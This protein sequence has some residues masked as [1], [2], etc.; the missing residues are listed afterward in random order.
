MREEREGKK[1]QAYPALPIVRA[2]TIF[3]WS[4]DLVG[5][6]WDSMIP[7]LSTSAVPL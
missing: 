3:Q 4:T 7:L 1:E 5:R 6:R 2:V